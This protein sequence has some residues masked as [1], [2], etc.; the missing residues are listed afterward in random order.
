M[1]TKIKTF[2]GNIGIGTTDPKDYN[3]NVNGSL[4]TTS[5]EVNGVQNA[6]VPIGL[7]APWYGS[8]DS[9]PSGWALCDGQPHP[10]TDGGGPITTPD[11][12]AKFIRGA[13]GD[14]PSPVAKGS[15]G[16]NNE[17]TLSEA[18]LLALHSHGVTVETGNANHSHGSDQIDA[19]HT[20]GG[21]SNQA[22]ALHDHE[23]AQQTPVGHSHGSGNSN[24]ANANHSHGATTQSEALHGH[25][26]NTSY[27]PHTHSIRDT[28]GYVYSIPGPD[29][30]FGHE[31]SPSVLATYSNA[32]HNHGRSNNTQS[33][34]SHGSTGY[35]DTG[36]H[37][38]VVANADT[39]HRHDISNNGATHDHSTPQVDAPHSHT[40]S[41]VYASHEHNASSANTGEASTFSVLNRYYALFYIM[42]I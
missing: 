10:R 15:T 28:R 19:Q 9:I 11:L 40:V 25:G 36:D 8:S 16:G 27:A 31:G 3:L 41:S 6:Q 13:D 2:G 21:N 26:T 30:L 1:T 14:A 4:K 29:G 32:P 35:T 23:T 12:R 39:N 20:H 5:L 17:A 38:H 33:P 7:I 24:T 18:S 34:H 37:T 42:K 22:N